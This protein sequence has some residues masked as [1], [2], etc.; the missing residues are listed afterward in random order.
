MPYC[1][2]PSY[3]RYKPKNLGLVVIDGKQHYLGKYGTPESLAEYNR[4][5][6]E[7]LVAGQT[8]A[9]QTNRPPPTVSEMILAF[10]R[11]AEQHE[12][13]ADGTP[14]GEQNNLRDALRPVRRL[15]GDTPAAEFG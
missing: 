5:I 11:P 9:G 15:Y 2:V 10:W 4:L 3:R 6:Q 8:P 7:W 1:R 13:Y 12:R 14:T